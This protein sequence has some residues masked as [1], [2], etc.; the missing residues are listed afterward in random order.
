MTAAVPRP[1]EINW[2]D[3]ILYPI[4]LTGLAGEQQA[5]DLIVDLYTDQPGADVLERF[6]CSIAPL[7]TFS[8]AGDCAGLAG[9]GKAG[10]IHYAHRLDDV[11]REHLSLPLSGGTLSA[12]GGSIEL[13]RIDA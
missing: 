10:T 9:H 7:V 2:H 4:S 12:S 3:G 6:S 11:G 8:H 5:L 13:K 1:D